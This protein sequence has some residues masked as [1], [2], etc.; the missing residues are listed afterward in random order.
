MVGQHLLRLL[1]AS[2]VRR[3]ALLCCSAGHQ[4]GV[5]LHDMTVPRAVCA[6]VLSLVKPCRRCALVVP[7]CEAFIS[8]RGHGHRCRVLNAT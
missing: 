8:C 7:P 1:A 2:T 6:I 5:S 4:H 3:A